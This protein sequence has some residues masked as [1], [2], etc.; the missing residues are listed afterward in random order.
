VA[1]F[2]RV[3]APAFFFFRFEVNWF[4]IRLLVGLGGGGRWTLALFVFWIVP[5]W[6]GFG[7]GCWLEIAG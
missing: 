4:V 7:G 1:I 5:W 2:N 6:D 3:G